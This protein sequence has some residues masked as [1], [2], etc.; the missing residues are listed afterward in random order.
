MDLVTADEMREMD[1]QTIESF[2][3]PGRLLMENAGRGAARILMREMPGLAAASVGVAAGR[4]NNG[5][6][7]F[8]IARYLFQQGID[9][10]VYLFSESSGLQ[11]DAAANF[12]LLGALGVPIAELPDESAFERHR[13][14]MAQRTIWVDALLGTGLKSEVKG[15]FRTVITFIN[16]QERPVLAV[17]IPSG[18]H[19]DTGRPCG[20]SIKATITATFAFAKT[21]HVQQPGASLTG[22]LHVV[23]IGIPPHIARKIDPRQRLLHPE[24]LRDIISE[25][26]PDI[27]KGGTGH[28]FVLAGAPGKSGAAAMTAMSALRAGAGLVTLGTPK[29]LMPAME[30]QVLEAMTVGLRETAEGRLSEE[31]GDQVLDLLEGMRCLALGPGI[32]TDPA[33]CRLVHRLVQESPVPVVIDADGLNNLAE[34]PEIL[35]NTHAPVILTPH[36]GEMARL[37]G[38]TTGEV[39]KDRIGCAREFAE[40]Y[41]SYVVLK[42][43]RTV[44]AQPDDQIYINPTGNPGM[45]SGGMGDVLTG[46][47]GG[48]IA[49][50]HSPDTAVRIAVFLHGAA[51]DELCASMGP[52]GYL[53]SDLMKQLPMSIAALKS[54]RAGKDAGCLKIPCQELL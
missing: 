52:F 45:A 29:S 27:H 20:S 54:G 18:L 12:K 39:Q 38:S 26:P 47:I 46:M 19:A 42:G 43:A 22:E 16:S 31:A 4:G 7:G 32:G 50:G 33:T 11:G 41:S 6:D 30:P 15:Y 9:V 40:S 44:I 34:E 48:F 8:V 36:P 5:G 3:L 17:D 53:A 13:S 35:I 2:G 28:V 14:E 49:Q 25:R 10:K 51:A 24:H 23:D 37:T 1:R 21:G